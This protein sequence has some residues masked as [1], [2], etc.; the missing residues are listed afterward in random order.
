MFIQ[1]IPPP[2][3]IY[4]SISGTYLFE[5][6]SSVSEFVFDYLLN[7]LK[8]DLIGNH[9]SRYNENMLLCFL[10]QIREN[11]NVNHCSMLFGISPGQLSKDFHRISMVFVSKLDHLWIRDMNNEE[12]H[13]VFFFFLITR[14]GVAILRKTK[15]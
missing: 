8:N 15:K 2:Q 10:Y 1:F 5:T 7:A 4:E 14:V 6:F 12:K 11:P 9:Q 3:P 13:N